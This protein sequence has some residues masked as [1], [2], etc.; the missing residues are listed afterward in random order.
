M[1]PPLAPLN[2][3]HARHLTRVFPSLSLPPSQSL[4]FTAQFAVG[5][6][7]PKDVQL[8]A[9]MLAPMLLLSLG[10]V[11]ALDRFV[12]PIDTGAKGKAAK[13]YGRV[14]TGSDDEGE[15]VR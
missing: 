14:G 15:E 11:F 13:A 9:L 8:Q 2:P 3:P 1:G 10:A 7:K 12:R 4:G 6:I 5:I